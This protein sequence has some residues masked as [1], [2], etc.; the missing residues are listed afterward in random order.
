MS[1]P[2]STPRRAV[3]IVGLAG[4]FPGASSLEAFWRNLRQGVESLST[5]TDE[6]Q[7]S[8][9]V[10]AATRAA[11]GWVPRGTVLEDAECFDAAFFGYAPREAQIMDPQHR[12]FLE[13]A[14]AALEH[15]GYAAE[16]PGTAI[17]VYAGA[18][19]NS[20]TFSQLVPNRDLIASVGGYQLML[21]SDKDFLST[22]VS[23]KLDLHGPSLAVQTA[24]S[25]SL[26]A[27]QVACQALLR[28]ECDMALAGG[29][30]V[31]FPQHVGYLYEEGMIFSPDG[32]CRPFDAA[33]RGTRGGAGAGV[34][35]LK[36]LEDA[37]ADRDTIH[38]VILGS[39][40]NNDG[41][42]KVGFTAPSV[43][44]QQE[45]IMTAQALAGVSADSISY[46]EAHGTATPLGD[47]IEITALTRAFRA[48]STAR[49]YCAIGSLKANLGHLDAAAGVAG[50]IKTVLALRHRELPPQINFSS[51][52]PQL[53][54]E[55]SPFRVVRTPE[56]WPE[57]S[58]PRRA[59][60]SSFGIGG[61][62][63]HVVLEEAPAPTPA[64]AL[65]DAQLLVLSAKSAA[66][67]DAAT[68][69]LAAYL[70]GDGVAPLA[71]VAYTLQVGRR[72]FPHR[73]SVVAS[74]V[75][76]AIGLLSAP[77]RAPVVTSE[78]TGGA[79]PVAFL[80]SGQGSQHA[81]MCAELYRTEEVFRSAVD[82]CCELLQPHFGRDLRQVLWRATDGEMSETQVA[83]PALFVAEY[84]LAVLWMHWGVQPAA[85]LGHSIGEYV[86]A[87]LA[88]V[89]SL[90][91]ALMLVAARG[92]L[93]A[94]MASGQMLA[95]RLAP[96][97]LRS[98]LLPGIEIAAI[99]GP[100]LC[101]I[102]GSVEGID[103]MTKALERDGVEHRP[104]H[105][106]HAFHSAMMEPA[107]AP[108]R[109]IVSRV[110]LSVPRRPVVSNVTGT[111]LTAEQATSPDYW[112]SHLRSP[113]LF[114]DGVKTLL[115]DAH[116]QLLE[117]GPGTALTAL[118][119]LTAGR[120]DASRVTAS[121]P[122][123]RE[124][125]GEVQSVLA[126]VGKLWAAGVQ[127]DW[128]AV[129]AS[130]S[131]HR[132]PL[133][134][135]PFEKVRHW[136]DVVQQQQA[137]VS[138]QSPA[139]AALENQRAD[140]ADWFFSPSWLRVPAL[141]RAA[142]APIQ[143]RWV[144]IGGDDE[145]THAV[146]GKLE[147]GGASVT[148]I[149]SGHA[150]SALSTDVVSAR[151]GEVDDYSALL[152]DFRSRGEPVRGIVS[153]RGVGT[154][155]GDE[156]DTELLHELMAL[157][158]AV[159]AIPSG[160]P[161]RLVVATAGSQSVLGE[162]ITHPERALAS[163]PVL[164]MP[165]EAEQLHATLLDVAPG[166]GD[167]DT[168]AHAIVTEAWSGAGEQF[169]AH[170]GGAR[171]VRRYSRVSL[172][173]VS[174]P[175]SLPLTPRAHY[176]ITGGLGGL[177]LAFAGWLSARV[178]ARL[179]LVSRTPLPPRDQWPTWRQAHGADDPVSVQL[180]AIAR[181][182]AD[183][184]EV[185][186]AAADVADESAMR[187]AVGEAEERF[188]P[189]RGIIHA[190]GLLGSALLVTTTRAEAEAC[191]SAKVT[192]TRVLTRVLGQREMDFVM[193]CGSI[194]AVAGFAGSTA[195]GAA[196]SFLDAFAMSSEKPTGWPTVSIDWFGWRD[197]G[198]AT[199]VAPN[200]GRSAV[201]NPDDIAP[202]EG[203][204]AF[205]RVLAAGVGQMVVSPFDVEAELLRRRRPARSAPRPAAVQAAAVAGPVAAVTSPRS[206][207]S[208]IDAPL[209]DVETQLAAIWQELLGV[210]SLGAHDNFFELGGH[211]LMAT[212]VMARIDS[213]FDVRLALRELFNAPTIRQLAAVIAGQMPPASVSSDPGGER[214]E[215]EL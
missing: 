59:G 9:G 116:I 63:A 193:L 164:S 163:G 96:Q 49:G 120:D 198:M 53:Q 99:N 199:H 127:V 169:V 110:S 191:L 78:V 75:A 93:M 132:V 14:W 125:R 158:A 173:E 170:R 188:G 159:V 118:A 131:L 34:V 141:R 74:S 24:C 67:L 95:V 7:A 195:Y 197:V 112:A 104:L 205:A 56:A 138:T 64:V 183:G 213:L 82:R 81:G 62:N 161:M 58:T 77:D 2:Q 3:A 70:S 171:F 86:A 126:A 168:C 143:G 27:V 160:A 60:V 73:R 210:E 147:A 18:G 90:E 10:D 83:Q 69:N 134:T 172:P 35:A 129:H 13:C 179:T 202:S 57:G 115:S 117:V 165:L 144:I 23:Y 39:A 122:H 100:T 38:A 55:T 91:D 85:M 54:L 139:S 190:A 102:S 51:P 162:R 215:F 52:N 208:P 46:V 1:A 41:A 194:S 175:E 8:A 12:I 130:E 92:R 111:W 25:T 109:E 94:G 42:G 72:A 47:P 182:E 152:R 4:R 45:V 148:T 11:P 123:P 153:L 37:I 26:V 84:A 137:T 89:F 206:G 196:N 36:R 174:S 108:F 17:G 128:D 66:A 31:S 180:A 50:L 97:E 43:D 192:G 155:A 113:V 203:T 21:A 181:I 124:D 22:R 184:G 65:R 5:F 103:A 15:A 79:P 28:Q 32:H 142:N 107:L 207:S 33:A 6:E 133:P 150:P 211:S 44:G 185:L 61:T 16:P 201:V 200:A 167:V 136:V 146:R 177:G 145:L 214:E 30:S 178:Q 119:R 98:R 88:G 29:V 140:L 204:D 19:M 189:V 80:F 101:T 186:V 71:D 187:R 149:V 212:R 76:E 156:P 176:L 114:A 209:G 68:T 20:Y 135:Y 157:G 106:S 121:S 166:D 151:L 40:I 105:T 87:H 154:P 48:S